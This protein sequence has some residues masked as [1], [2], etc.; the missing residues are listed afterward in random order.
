M[1][2]IDL[3]VATAMLLGLAAGELRIPRIT[4]GNRMHTNRA[5]AGSVE[6]A[7][8]IAAAEAKRARKAARGARS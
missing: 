7:E 6:A 8:R 2:R 3:N 5:P 1:K 4:D